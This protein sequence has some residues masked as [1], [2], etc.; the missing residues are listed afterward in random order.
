MCVLEIG[1]GERFSGG[2]PLGG[3]TPKATWALREEWTAGPSHVATNNTMTNTGKRH[4]SIFLS[5]MS[6]NRF[7]FPSKLSSHFMSNARFSPWP[8]PFGPRLCTTDGC[9]RLVLFSS[10]LP[11]TR[12]LHLLHWG[13]RLFSGDRAPRAAEIDRDFFSFVATRIVATFGIC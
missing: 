4:V 2:T 13:F 10:R 8:P 7:L 5:R 1:E 9:S 12:A 6:D 11:G 3:V